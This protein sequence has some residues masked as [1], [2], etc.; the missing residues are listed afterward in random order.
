MSPSEPESVEDARGGVYA[1]MRHDA[2]C[3][4]RAGDPDWVTEGQCTCLLPSLLDE[5]EAAV[6]RDE[7]GAARVDTSMTAR[8]EAAEKALR[9]IQAR[10][11]SARFV[12]DAWEVLLIAERAL[13][14]AA[15][16]EEA[17]DA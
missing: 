11:R 12:A 2:V 14:S 17:T 7:R 3:E 5:Y 15:P 1:E 16:A 4:R 10:M 13:A 6:R 9:E 8:A